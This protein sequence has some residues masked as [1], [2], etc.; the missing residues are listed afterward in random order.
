MQQAA[1]EVD[2]VA[3][4]VVEVVVASSGEA[5]E[6]IEVVAVL[7]AGGRVIG[8]ALLVAITTLLTEMSATDVELRSRLVVAVVVAA[9][10]ARKEVG[11]RAT[12]VADQD[13]TTT[14][15]LTTVGHEM[16]AD[17]VI[18]MVIHVVSTIIN[19][20]PT[21]TEIGTARETII[22]EE[23]VTSGIVKIGA[24]IMAVA[25]V[26]HLGAVTGVVIGGKDLI[27]T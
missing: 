18:G 25:A 14:Q 11:D 12:I 16:A 5:K 22:I 10:P 3:A 17:R 6:V 23:M 2:F 15:D 26:G 27:D 24:E 9:E 4:A 8:C 21:E 13:T 7:E 19:V 1:S 20:M